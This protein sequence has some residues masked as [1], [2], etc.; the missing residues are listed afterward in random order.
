MGVVNRVWPLLPLLLAAPVA[1]AAR[2]WERNVTVQAVE[3]VSPPLP[4]PEAQ[5]RFQ[6]AVARG[7]ALLQLGLYTPARAALGEALRDWPDHSE[8]LFL[9]ARA[10]L[11]VGYLNWNRA[12]IEEATSDVRSAQ[13]LDPG[14]RE[15]QLF[16]ELLDGL[17]Q[18]MPAP[19]KSPERP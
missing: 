9:R 11:I 2:P 4:D 14:D 10:T 6:E 18:R 16:G 13:R 3:G 15:L 1:H 5:V 12:L 7:R 8:A 19:K 17:L